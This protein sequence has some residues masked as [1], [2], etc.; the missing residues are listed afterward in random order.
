M[1]SKVLDMENSLLLSFWQSFVDDDA[2][3]TYFF[4]G[5][6]LIST[7]VID[8]WTPLI[9]EFTCI[10]RHVVFGQITFPFDKQTNN[11]GW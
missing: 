7:R 4:I 2:D 3:Y 11:E 9:I 1:P 5:Y 8:A 6:I 10:S